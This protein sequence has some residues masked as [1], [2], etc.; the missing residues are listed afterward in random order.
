MVRW[1]MRVGGCNYSDS[2]PF[3]LVGYMRG[4]N[5]N[6]TLILMLGVRICVLCGGY[7][8]LFNEAFRPQS[9]TIFSIHTWFCIEC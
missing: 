4:I 9:I 3:R 5:E 8:Q 7:S 2:P 1:S 6:S